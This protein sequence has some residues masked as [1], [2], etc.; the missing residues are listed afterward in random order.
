MTTTA[1]PEAGRNAGGLDGPVSGLLAPFLRALL[2]TDEHP[3]R[4][5]FEFW[6][7]STFGPAD[8]V[9]TVGVRS[10]AALGR[11]LWSP[12]EF[13]V[14]RAF[15]A[16]DLDVS[17]D[18]FEVIA[19]LRDVSPSHL[20]SDPAQLWAAARAAR[21]L[22]VLRRPPA[23]PREE[24]RTPKG[25]LHSKR[26]DAAA[27]SHHYDVGND[28]YRL[29][30]GESM[31]YSCA[32]FVDDTVDLATAQ[33]AKHDLVCRKLGLA[34]GPP[35]RLLDVGCG[36]GSM[37]IHAATTYGARVLGVTI[38]ETQAAMARKRVADA[39]VADLVSIELT[40]YRDLDGETFDAISSIGMFEHVGRRNAPK[41][42]ETLFA[43]LR[44][45]GRLLNHAITSVGGS[46]MSGRTFLNR[47]VFP[48]GELLDVGD[49]IMLM[50]QAG[51]EV[52]DVECLREHYAMTL[53]RW[54]ANLQANWD[55]AVAL[56]SEGRARV[57]LLYMAASAVGFDDGGVSIH[58]VLGARPDPTGASG[59]P[60]SR[61]DWDP[62]SA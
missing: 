59:M 17:G 49:A 13:G 56:T 60:R 12:G 37:A 50:G 58:Q 41:Y 52:R 45:Q 3:L 7:G 40:D 47:Y 15:V 39:G 31:T 21:R 23:P 6:D 33:A 10:A 27:I 16:G 19:A 29:V 54:V 8:A 22:G 57:W 26:R 35:A 9:G 43:L 36:W 32:R 5:R 28:F 30:L 51:F 53:R 2:R 38:S 55:E 62:I 44:P 4:V 18:V 1:E 14:T 46:K 24:Y 48:D 42:F 11:I 34:D 25:L 20:K 61:R